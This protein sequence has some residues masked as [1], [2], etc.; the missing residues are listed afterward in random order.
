MHGVLYLGYFVCASLLEDLKF[1]LYDF[2][3][4]RPTETTH[5][6]SISGHSFYA[7]WVSVLF[8]YFLVV[9][10]RT[11]NPEWFYY[12]GRRINPKK[13][14]QKWWLKN[15]FGSSV[16]YTFWRP[17]TKGEEVLRPKE[18]VDLK[19]HI[20]IFL[21][22]LMA[23]FLVTHLTCTFLYGYHSLKQILFGASFS[24]MFVGFLVLFCEFVFVLEHQV[25]KENVMK[26]RR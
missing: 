1:R 10:R 7:F 18:K 25:I 22:I 13:I 17:P 20:K 14:F 2:A 11:L 23:M 15:P 8:V 21:G 12:E 24:S 16:E 9:L 5:P 3:C 19:I 4:S 26:K 6:N